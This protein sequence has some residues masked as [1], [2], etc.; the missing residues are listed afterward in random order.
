MIVHFYDRKTMVYTAC[1]ELPN[2]VETTDNGE[3]VTC[4][5]CEEI[6]TKQKGESC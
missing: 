2:W 4:G 5:L 3:Q 1:K 6:L